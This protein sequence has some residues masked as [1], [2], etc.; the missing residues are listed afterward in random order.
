MRQWQAGDSVGTVILWDHATWPEHADFDLRVCVFSLSSRLQ[1]HM[2]MPVYWRD[3]AETAKHEEGPFRWPHLHLCFLATFSILDIGS[4]QLW[5]RTWAPAAFSVF[6]P[7]T[8]TWQA[9]IY[10]T[11]RHSGRA[12]GKGGGY[13]MLFSSKENKWMQSS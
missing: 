12:A 9:G 6:V 4:W 3:V 2:L 13:A 7:S 8:D 1:W 5:H 11:C 10:H